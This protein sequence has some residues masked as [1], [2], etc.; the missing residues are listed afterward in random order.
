MFAFLY[1]PIACVPQE[2]ILRYP[3]KKFDLKKEKKRCM[4][5]IMIYLYLYFGKN[6]IGMAAPKLYS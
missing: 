4:Y 2:G 5:F 1:S 3:D 6:V